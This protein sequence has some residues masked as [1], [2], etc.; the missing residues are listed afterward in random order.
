MRSFFGGPRLLLLG[1]ERRVFVRHVRRE[2]D[3][4]A[5][6][7]QVVVRRARQGDGAAAVRV[8]AFADK[9]DHAIVRAA[10]RAQ[11]KLVYLAA[12]H[13][14]TR[15]SNRTHPARSLLVATFPQRQTAL[16]RSSL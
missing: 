6:T 11:T 1:A 12:I 8:G 16:E 14:E 2:K 4:L 10:E 7:A 15:Q 9:G 5:L 13:R 3:R